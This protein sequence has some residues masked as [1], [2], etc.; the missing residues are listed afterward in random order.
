M[1]VS[2]LQAPPVYLSFHEVYCRGKTERQS[3]SHVWGYHRKL[4]KEV[5]GTVDGKGESGMDMKGVVGLV[6]GKGGPITDISWAGG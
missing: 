1:I 4:G 6:N 5:L 2:S 3:F